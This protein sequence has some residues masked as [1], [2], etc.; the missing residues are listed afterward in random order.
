[1]PVT[2]I[3]AADERRE[4]AR[5]H[6]L[7]FVHLSDPEARHGAT[8]LAWR[9]FAPVVGHVRGLFDAE[10]SRTSSSLSGCFRLPGGRVVAAYLVGESSAR[11]V[12]AIL[13]GAARAGGLKLPRRPLRVIE[14]LALVVDGDWRGLG[15]GKALRELPKDLG[16]DMVIG[17]QA[18]VL[19]NL[20]EWLG[21]RELVAEYP[22]SWFTAASYAPDVVLRGI[23]PAPKPST[24][25]R[26]AI[27]GGAPAS[28]I[29]SRTNEG[30]VMVIVGWQVDL[31][32]EA[33]SISPIT[34]IA[35]VGTPGILP[36]EVARR[37][38]IEELSGIQGDIDEGD[39]GG[40]LKDDPDV[41]TKIAS[42]REEMEA[43]VDPAP[44]KLD[45]AQQAALAALLEDGEG[46]GYFEL[47]EASAPALLQAWFMGRSTPSAVADAA[48]DEGL[49]SL[50][51]TLDAGRAAVP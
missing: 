40:R 35:A 14:G 48:R 30:G 42:R 10:V 51:G 4:L 34:D 2:A 27:P 5:R 19:D 39:A 25:R 1:M 33:T 7:Q 47:I 26:Q 31:D 16:A 41:V 45:H 38:A 36:F 17:Q 20:R 24:L 21:V 32:E 37:A 6:G 44:P 18:K 49:D 12:A 22:G 23:D 8:E 9:E 29:G 15:L 43:M 3:P 46:S 11:A 28:A 50:S 13:S